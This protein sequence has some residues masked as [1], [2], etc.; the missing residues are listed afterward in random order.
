MFIIECEVKS[1]F[2]HYF[3]VSETKR[4]NICMTLSLFVTGHPQYHSSN[5]PEDTHLTIN[6]SVP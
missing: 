1:I 3:T 6:H 2:S 5:I 4:P